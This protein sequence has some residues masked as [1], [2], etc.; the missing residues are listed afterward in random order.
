MATVLP[1]REG[2]TVEL[3]VFREVLGTNLPLLPRGQPHSRA[4]HVDPVPRVVGAAERRLCA[5]L[6]RVGAAP[7]GAD[8]RLGAGRQDDAQAGAGADFGAVEG[9]GSIADSQARATA[10][11]EDLVV[12]PGI[13]QGT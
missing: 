3:A 9:V 6:G 12:L 10:V 8:R 1:S 4:G 11:R 2:K 5:V 13:R 7:A